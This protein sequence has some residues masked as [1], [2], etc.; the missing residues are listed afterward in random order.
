MCG[1]FKSNGF[2]QVSVTRRT[3]K[4]HFLSSNFMHS[5]LK[6]STNRHMKPLYKTCQ[7]SSCCSC[8]FQWE[9]CFSKQLADSFFSFSHL[10]SVFFLLWDSDSESIKVYFR[11]IACSLNMDLN[12]KRLL[13][14]WRVRRDPCLW[15][16]ITYWQQVL[17]GVRPQ[18]QSVLDSTPGRDRESED[19][20]LRPAGRKKR[21]KPSF[22]HGLVDFYILLRTSWNNLLNV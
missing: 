18:S 9:G 20:S 14:K 1:V 15:T 11:G 12:V 6:T 3:E 22:S 21:R 16:V 5:L 2:L 8:T 17:T 13:F 19:F 7:P 10:R 4:N